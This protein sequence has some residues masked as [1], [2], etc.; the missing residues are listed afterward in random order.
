MMV[1]KMREQVL[2]EQ[3]FSSLGVFMGFDGGEACAARAG[4][5]EGV[6]R[7]VDAVGGGGDG[8]RGDQQ[9]EEQEGGGRQCCHCSRGVRRLPSGGLAQLRRMN[10]IYVRP[11]Y[12]L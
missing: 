1:R 8:E 4:N 6:R 2:Q 12:S 7:A 5:A 9:Q 11:E 10:P 3:G